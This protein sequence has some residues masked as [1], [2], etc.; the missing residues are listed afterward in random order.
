MPVRRI[1]RHLAFAASVV[2]VASPGVCR[3]SDD[4]IRAL[5]KAYNGF[6]QD[7]FTV[8]ERQPGNI[9]F[10]PYSVG[11]AMAM[12]MSGARGE[13]QSEML[14]A[15]RFTQTP[16]QVDSANGP[17]AAALQSYAKQLPAQPSPREQ[18]AKLGLD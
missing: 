2:L 3:A 13:T 10:S 15:M 17:L 16:S 1:A 11:V 5:A 6:G 7:V 8:L 12:T 14:S 4:D 18:C 9:V